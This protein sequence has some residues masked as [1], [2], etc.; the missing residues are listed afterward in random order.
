MTAVT[1]SDQGL[2]KKLSLLKLT[3][4]CNHNYVTLLHSKKVTRN[5]SGMTL[6]IDGNV[7]EVI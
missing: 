1:Q 6:H 2:P 3:G 7:R 5:T 4:L